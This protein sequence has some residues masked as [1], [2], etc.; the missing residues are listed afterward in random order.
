MISYICFDVHEIAVWIHNT[1]NYPAEERNI[2]IL[3]NIDPSLVSGLIVSVR[4]FFENS[5]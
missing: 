4:W 2:S 1:I 3:L 5:S